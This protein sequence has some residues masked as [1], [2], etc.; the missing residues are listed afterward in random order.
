MHVVG[1][2]AVGLGAETSPGCARGMR[3]PLRH[4]WCRPACRPKVKEG[5]TIDLEA[6]Q[7]D[8]AAFREEERRLA[9]VVSE[10]HRGGSW[11]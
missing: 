9:H 11:Q 4:P 3:A 5:E 10:L 7:R 2:G 1:S 8:A 6:F